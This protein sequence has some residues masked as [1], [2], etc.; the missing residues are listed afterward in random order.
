MNEPKNAA[1][2][3][4]IST[5]DC[6]MWQDMHSLG[7]VKGNV[8]MSRNVVK[9]LLG[10]LKTIVGGEVETWTSLLE[11]A[12]AMAEARMRGQAA[13]MGADCVVGVRFTTAF[14]EDVVEAFAYGAA[15]R[16]P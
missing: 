8:A 11:E 12:R 10:S 15:M 13:E 4:V 3:I 6:P 16:M 2:R 7:L 1:D 5:V 9:D 14:A